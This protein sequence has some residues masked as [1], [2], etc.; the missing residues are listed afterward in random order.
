M[1][2]DLLTLANQIIQAITPYLPFLGGVAGGI[3]NAI[4]GKVGE[5]VYDKGKEEV[6]LL[7]N[8]VEHRFEK[9][10]PADQGS[11]SRA[12][13]N[14]VA[15]PATYTTIFKD[16]LLALLKADPTFAQDLSNMLDANPAIFQ[17][18]RAQ[19]EALVFDNEQKNTFGEGT[20]IIEGKGK[21]RSE[22][23]SRLSVAKNRK[24]EK[25]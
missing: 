5:D 14:Y 11:A 15:E 24:G 23:N 1:I 6:K 16:R 4:I 7:Y 12:L 21:A 9:E 19:D 10:K 2:S 8:V 3:G 18:I 17:I 13:Q 25:R 20:Q 22:G